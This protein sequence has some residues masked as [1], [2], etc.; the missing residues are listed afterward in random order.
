MIFLGLFRFFFV[1]EEVVF[2]LFVLFLLYI[3]FDV[4]EWRRLLKLILI[5]WKLDVVLLKC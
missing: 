5:G 1:I 2:Y 3:I 4:S